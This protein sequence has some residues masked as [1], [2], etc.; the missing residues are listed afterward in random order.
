MRPRY[1]HTGRRSGRRR[2]A[3]TERAILASLE[4]A[5]LPLRTSDIAPGYDRDDV[6]LVTERLIREGFIIRIV[7]RYRLA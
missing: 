3:R 7:D 5:P 6:A 1:L 4:R 2:E